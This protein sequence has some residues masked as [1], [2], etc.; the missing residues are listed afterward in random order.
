MA[1]REPRKVGTSEVI[2]RTERATMGIAPLTITSVDQLNNY[3]RNVAR[4]DIPQYRWRAGEYEIE[5]Y[6][7][8][9]RVGWS[10]SKADVVRM[11]NEYMRGNQ[12]DKAIIFERLTDA[13]FHPEAARIVNWHKDITRRLRNANR[14]I[15]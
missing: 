15:K 12:R 11:A 9:E 1:I 3:S 13:N 2:G 10:F 4:E 8:N 14:G 7:E 5:V 6:A